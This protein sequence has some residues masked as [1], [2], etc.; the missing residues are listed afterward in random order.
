MEYCSR[1]KEYMYGASVCQCVKFVVID[2]DGEDI[3]FFANNEEAAAEAYAVWYNR[4]EYDLMNSSKNIM[5]NGNSYRVSAE[6]DIC[7]SITKT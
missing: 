4:D 7:Y 6:P 2:E 5:I 1:C 3:E